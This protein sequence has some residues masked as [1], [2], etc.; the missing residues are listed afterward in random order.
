MLMVHVATYQGELVGW[1]LTL[2]GGSA[3]LG[4]AEPA[5]L[6]PHDLCG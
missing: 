6:G 4:G 5:L 2:V 3:C 1:N